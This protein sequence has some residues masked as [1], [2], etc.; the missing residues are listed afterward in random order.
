MKEPIFVEE[1]MHPGFLEWQR[2]R[3]QGN[4]IKQYFGHAH[5]IFTSPKGKISMIHVKTGINFEEDFIY[6][7]HSFEK[8]F[9]D[10]ER[11]QTM[12]EAI[13]AIERYL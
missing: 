2:A 7:I 4:N 11:F 9:S 10:V 1:K 5:W 6:E 3:K 13:K 12:E 8:L